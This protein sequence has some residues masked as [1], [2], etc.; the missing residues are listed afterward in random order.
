MRSGAL[1][2]EACGSRFPPRIPSALGRLVR[3]IAIATAS[4]ITSILL[5]L[6]AF[7]LHH[8]ERNAFTRGS[9]VDERP[10][11]VHHLSL[12]LSLSLSSSTR[13][14][15]FTRFLQKTKIPRSAFVSSS[16]P[17]PGRMRLRE[18]GSFFFPSLGNNVL[19]KA[20]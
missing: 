16:I 14:H 12:P 7:L 10:L 18:L 20:Y 17:R 15:P 1:I 13:C 5:P 2:F 19:W 3:Q 9:I 6:A 11:P 8:H 4:L